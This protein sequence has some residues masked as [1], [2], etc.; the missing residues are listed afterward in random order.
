MWD[1]VFRKWSHNA[2]RKKSEVA[3][4]GSKVTSEKRATS[5]ERVRSRE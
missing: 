1:P 4:V 2:R 5:E 3:R